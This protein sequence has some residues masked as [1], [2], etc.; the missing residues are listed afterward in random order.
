[1]L[2]LKVLIRWQTAILFAFCFAGCRQRPAAYKYLP[3]PVEGWEQGDTLRYHI[4]SLNESGIYQLKLGLRV[5]ASRPYPFQSIWLAIRQNWY[6]PDTT[7]TDT[8][9]CRLTD[10]KGDVSGRGVSLYTLTRPVK[11]MKLHKGTS[12][13]IGIIHI[14]RREMLPGVADIGIRLERKP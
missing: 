5:S 3:A 12:A 13:D 10:N 2:Y 6:N 4:D 14:M 8:V 1:M 9:E 7:F 11:L